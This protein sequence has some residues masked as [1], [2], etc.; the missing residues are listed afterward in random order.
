MDFAK[1]YYECLKNRDFGCMITFSTKERQEKH[2]KICMK[3]EEIKQNP[4]VIQ[5]EL[6]NTISNLDKLC[7]IYQLTDQ[8]RKNT[9]FILLI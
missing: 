2:S 9:N 4:T 3:P 5:I 1:N 7:K 8:E 6:G